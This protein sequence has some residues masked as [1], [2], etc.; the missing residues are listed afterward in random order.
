MAPWF[1]WTE[2]HTLVYQSKRYLQVGTPSFKQIKAQWLFLHSVGNNPVNAIQRIPCGCN[3]SCTLKKAMS[4]QKN[5]S[6]EGDKMR[7]TRSTSGNPLKSKWEGKWNMRGNVR[8]NITSV[9]VVLPFLQTSI[10]VSCYVTYI[11]VTLGLILCLVLIVRM[12]I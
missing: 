8:G 4:D 7:K 5:P 10:Y 11:M 6:T 1:R 3:K 2:C 12:A 9:F